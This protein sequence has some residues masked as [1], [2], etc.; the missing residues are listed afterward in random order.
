MLY[1]DTSALVPAFIR[2]ATSDAVL[3]LLESTDE[4]IALSEWSLVEFASAASMKVRV[5]EITRR[6]ANQATLRA[7]AFAEKYCVIAVPGQTEF[8]QAA[9]MIATD[10]IK[11]RAGDALHLAIANS[12]SARG[13]LCL[14]KAMAEGAKALGMSVVSV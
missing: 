6:F 12:L 10:G 3:E 2:E 7:R 8:R 13:I 14:D 4:R 1:V 5:G 11:L 9:A